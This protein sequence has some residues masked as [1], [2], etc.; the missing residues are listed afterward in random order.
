MTEEE[1][2]LSLILLGLT[3]TTN[4][5]IHGTPKLYRYKYSNKNLRVYVSHRNYMR[6]KLNTPKDSLG[7]LFSSDSNTTAIREK[8]IKLL[9]ELDDL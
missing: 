5:G 7:I 9:G 4:D 1:F 3:D 2:K 6:V 8:I